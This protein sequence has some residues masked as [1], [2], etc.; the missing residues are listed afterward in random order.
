MMCCFVGFMLYVAII[1][2]FNYV[3]VKSQ[4]NKVLMDALNFLPD[5]MKLE[6]AI[7]E[8]YMTLSWNLNGRDPYVFSKKSK[9]IASDSR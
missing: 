5:D 8:D 7:T 1:P 9:D 3:F 4:P 2:A 6:D